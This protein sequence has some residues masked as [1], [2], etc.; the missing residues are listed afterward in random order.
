MPTKKSVSKETFSAESQ[1]LAAKLLDFQRTLGA[2]LRALDTLMQSL[3]RQTDFSGSTLKLV[4]DFLKDGVF[5]K[6]TIETEREILKET[7]KFKDLTIVRGETFLDEQ[8]TATL[9][10]LEEQRRALRSGK[11]RVNR[12][13]G[14]EA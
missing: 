4:D 2:R 3:S 5:D 10:K 9:A 13:N 8:K 6:Q 1:A 11:L 14:E 12:R 7:R